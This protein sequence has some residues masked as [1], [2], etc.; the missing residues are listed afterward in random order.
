MDK[1]FPVRT[2]LGCYNKRNKNELL[3][4]VKSNSGKVLLDS[5]GKAEGRG[6]YIC[7]NI[8]CVEKL[9]K[10]KR[11]NKVLKMNVNEEIYEEIRKEIESRM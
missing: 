2:C 8:D 9:I 5:T 6:S 1:E 10:N 3:R 7:C 4:I 11:L